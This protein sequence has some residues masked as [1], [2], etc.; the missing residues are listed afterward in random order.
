MGSRKL[1][2]VQDPGL[3]TGCGMFERHSREAVSSRLRLREYDYSTPGSY[4]VTICTAD[5][6][7]AFGDVHDSTMKLS[8]AGAVVDSWWNSIPSQ[9]PDVLL[10]TR[11]VMPNHIHG[12]V[13]IGSA[14]VPTT[15]CAL[16]GL[17]EIMRWFKS[18]STRDY[19]LGVHTEGWPRF[20]GRL[21]QQGYYDHIVRSEQSLSRIRSYIASNPSRWESDEYHPQYIT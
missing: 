1:P 8:P 21:W 17:S 9:F 18:Q 13:V 6:F 7:C 12:V 5:R 20:P 3:P 11:V 14:F 19:I 4:F 16:P 2:W 10:D 15:D